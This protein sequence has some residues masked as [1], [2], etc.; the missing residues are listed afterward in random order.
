MRTTLSVPL[1]KCRG[2]GKK[3][4]AIKLARS[5]W[6]RIQPSTRN[7]STDYLYLA[8]EDKSMWWDHKGGKDPERQSCSFTLGHDRY[9][10][11][12]H[13]KGVQRQL[14]CH[15]DFQLRIN[16]GKTV[17]KDFRLNRRRLR[18][19]GCIDRF[20][21]RKIVHYPHDSSESSNR[22]FFKVI[23]G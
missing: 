11:F 21:A 17:R 7:Q 12:R 5:Q 20:S 18:K 16:D 2:L 3:C 15:E 13:V 23:S 4:R 10:L 1:R 22:H 14:L 19:A 6:S 8:T 9:E